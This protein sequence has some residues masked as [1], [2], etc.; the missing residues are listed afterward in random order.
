MINQDYKQ[1]SYILKNKIGH[2]LAFSWRGVSVKDKFL[3]PFYIEKKKP[4]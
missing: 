3:N 1:G 2:S 4:E